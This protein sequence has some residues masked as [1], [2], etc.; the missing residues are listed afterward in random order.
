MDRQSQ[1]VEND[2]A[3]HQLIYFLKDKYQQ[4][5]KGRDDEGRQNK[6]ESRDRYYG[7]HTEQIWSGITEETVENEIMRFGIS[8][9]SSLHASSTR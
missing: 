7:Q 1:S 5:R 4:R 3:R 8:F 9:F 2:S 6:N